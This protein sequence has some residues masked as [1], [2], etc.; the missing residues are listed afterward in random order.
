MSGEIGLSVCEG[1]EGAEATTSSITLRFFPAGGPALS[2]AKRRDLRETHRLKRSSVGPGSA[3]CLR[4]LSSGKNGGWKREN[5]RNKHRHPDE[6]QG[7]VHRARRSRVRTYPAHRHRSDRAR[8][9]KISLYD[10]GPDLRQ[11]DG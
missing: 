2:R 9:A 6:S 7:P 5:E 3:A 10:L 1:E 11:D 4:R 8:L